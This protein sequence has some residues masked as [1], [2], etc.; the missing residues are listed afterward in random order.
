MLAGVVALLL[1]CEVLFRL[2]PVSSSTQSGYYID[3]QIP[4]YPPHHRWRVATG[5]DLRNPQQLASNGHGFVSA[6]EFTP[7][8]RAIGLIGDSYVEASMLPSGDRPGAQLELALSARRPV[9]AM[10]SPGSSLLDYAERI[11]FASQNSGVRDFVV[12]MEVGDVRQALC[13]SG[14]VISACVDRLTLQPQTVHIA[15]P[16]AV[17]RILRESALM[18]YIV[19]QLKLTP[20]GLWQ[21]LLSSASAAPARGPRPGGATAMDDSAVTRQIDTIVG[22]FFQRIAPFANGRLVF[23]MDAAHSSATRLTSLQAL[24]RSR[25]MRLA[26]EHG[27]AVVDLEPLYAAHYAR[28]SHS[29]EVGPYD[30]QLNAD[31]VRIVAQAAARALNGVSEIAAR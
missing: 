2:L 27:A 1:A 9:Y 7:D 24:E 20:E 13:G 11:R 17:K 21:Q 29:L 8:P 25:F 18:N 10:G 5:W 3:P 30:H 14:N 22:V 26:G 4:T 19:G 23:V 28:S 6:R 16:S 12:W 15:E 31:G